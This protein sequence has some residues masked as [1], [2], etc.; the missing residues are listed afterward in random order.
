MKTKALVI[1]TCS[2]VISLFID[3]CH[4]QK[5]NIHWGPQSM[6]Y[7]K[8]KYGKRFVSEDNNRV[9]KR[10]LNSLHALLKGPQVLRMNCSDDSMR[11]P[12][13][14]KLTSLVHRS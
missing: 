4:A 1:W 2:L 13:L 9:W 10:G 8:G 14:K 3:Y 6:M 11:M 5:L 7:L 12:G